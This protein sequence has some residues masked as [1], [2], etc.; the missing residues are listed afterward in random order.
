ML[1]RIL[2]SCCLLL[3]APLAHSAQRIEPDHGSLQSHIDDASPG[4]E[5]LLGEGVHRGNIIIDKPLTL[6]GDPG[7]ILDAEG[8]GDVIRVTAADVR[9][10]GLTLRNSGYNLTDMNAGIHGERGAHRLH[11]EDITMDNVAFGIWLWHAEAPT[12][13]GNRITGNTEVR[14]QDRGDAIR[15]YNID[16]GLIAGNDIRDAR[17]AI[18]V[19][20]SRDLEFRGNRLRDSRFGIHYM[21]THGSLLIDNHTSGTRAGYALM[22]SRDLEVLNNRSENDRNYGILMNYVNYSTIAGNDISGITAW[23]GM[24]GEGDEHG[25][26]LGAEGKALFI[27]NSQANEIHNNRV[28][29]SELGIHLTAGSENNRLYHNAFINNRQQVMYVSTRTQEWSVDGKGNYWSDYLGWD[30]AGDGVGDTAY[31]PNDAVDRLLWRYPSARLLM[32]SPAVVALRWVQRQF[33]I[34]RAQGV[35]DSAPLMREPPIGGIRP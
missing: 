33:P 23:H 29:D 27:Y 30:L 15:L 18:Y 31:E 14:S 19:D 32:H 24:A 34:F 2:V 8:H 20:T 35:R 4:S 16:G 5:L 11:V 6:R 28:A 25:V 7:A 13:I 10:E 17:D 3:L 1:L 22:M 12:L 26:T 9:I 21:F